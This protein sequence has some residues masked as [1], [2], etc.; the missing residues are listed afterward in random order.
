MQFMLCTFSLGSWWPDSGATT[1]SNWWNWKIDLIRNR[2]K[3]RAKA[4]A[5]AWWWPMV[6]PN[7]CCRWMCTVSECV[8]SVVSPALANGMHS[9]LSCVQWWFCATFMAVAWI[10]IVEMNTTNLIAF[11][12]F[13][14][15]SFFA[16]NVLAHSFRFSRIRSLQPSPTPLFI[17]IFCPS[18]RPWI[19]DVCSLHFAP[20]YILCFMRDANGKTSRAECSAEKS[21]YTNGRCTHI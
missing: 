18:S 11:L 1:L 2:G 10:W 3:C 12:C 7:K 15:V 4:E 13:N 16:L 9:W 6:I 19:V 20:S 14:F 17:L 5:I 21:I 8:Y